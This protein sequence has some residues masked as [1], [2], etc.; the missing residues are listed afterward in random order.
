LLGFLPLAIIENAQEENPGEFGDILQRA[1]AVG[2]AQDV[3][4]TLDVGIKAGLCCEFTCAGAH[5]VFISTD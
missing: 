1:R 2:T 3:A 5:A 4:N